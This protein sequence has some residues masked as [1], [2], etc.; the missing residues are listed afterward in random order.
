MIDS[1]YNPYRYSAYN[2]LTHI[3]VKV[4]SEHVVRNTTDE[5]G[6]TRYGGELVLSHNGGGAKKDQIMNIAVFLEPGHE[7]KNPE[8]Q[9]L[10]KSWE[11][12]HDLEQYCDLVVC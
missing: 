1:C 7:K 8:L 11:G 9:K 4:P 10:L 2:Y 6:Y 3:S 12:E 5:K